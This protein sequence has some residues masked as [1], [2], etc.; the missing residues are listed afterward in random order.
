M[1]VLIAL[2]PPRVLGNS[3]KSSDYYVAR[4]CEPYPDLYIYGLGQ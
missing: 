2:N 3:L 4:A 1:K